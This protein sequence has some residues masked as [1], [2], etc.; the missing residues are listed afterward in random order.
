MNDIEFI[1]DIKSRKLAYKILKEK[2][3]AYGGIKFY[4]FFLVASILLLYDS[5]TNGFIFYL[6]IVAII[7]SSINLYI[8]FIERKFYKNK[9]SYKY[10]LSDK[11]S[12]IERVCKNRKKRFKILY[13]RLYKNGLFIYHTGGCVFL[14][15]EQMNSEHIE[16]LYNLKKL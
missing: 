8:K 16:L 11:N 3:K 5:K 6:S 2:N 14:S 13:S 10:I 7:L 1:E 9:K 15:K 4:I 12:T